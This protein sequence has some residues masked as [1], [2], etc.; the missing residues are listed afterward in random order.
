M[1]SNGGASHAQ[2]L[3]VEGKKVKKNEKNGVQSGGICTDESEEGQKG[4]GASENKKM[5]ED[6]V[7]SKKAEETVVKSKKEQKTMVDDTE[8]E[9]SCVSLWPWHGHE[10]AVRA[11]D[12]LN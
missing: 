1:E 3:V 4:G 12:R 11:H 7:K 6:V 9:F 5:V 2:N 8:E 10:R